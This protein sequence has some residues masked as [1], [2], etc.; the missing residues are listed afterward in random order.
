[1]VCEKCEVR[2]YHQSVLINSQAIKVA[3]LEKGA[4]DVLAEEYLSMPMFR[5]KW[6]NVLIIPIKKDIMNLDFRNNEIL[7]EV[8]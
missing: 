2:F 8:C 6:L 4:L 3:L 5:G 1:M 7:V